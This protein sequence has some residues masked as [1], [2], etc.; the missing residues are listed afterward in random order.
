ME[1]LWEKEKLLVENI[2]G[3]GENASNQHFLLFPQCFFFFMG[4][5]GGIVLQ[6]VTLFFFRRPAQINRWPL[7]ERLARLNFIG[8]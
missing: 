1:T 8:V 4:D 6:R 5:K 3:K 2:V 7:N